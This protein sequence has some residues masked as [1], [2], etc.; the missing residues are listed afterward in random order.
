V[1]RSIYPPSHDRKHGRWALIRFGGH[2]PQ[3]ECDVDVADQGKE[4]HLM[5]FRAFAAAPTGSF[6]QSPLMCWPRHL[7]TNAAVSSLKFR[8]RIGHDR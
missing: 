2:L 8:V 1:R 7:P 6:L 4:A 5:E 3:R